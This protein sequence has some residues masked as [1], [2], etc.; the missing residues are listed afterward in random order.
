MR[1][2]PALAALT[3]TLL[4]ALPAGA[5]TSLGQALYEARCDKCHDTSVHARNPRSAKSFDEIR[6][7]V[8]RWD[9]ELGTA[10]TDEEINEVARY[11]NERYYKFPCPPSVC[12]DEQA[13]LR[14]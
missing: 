1:P 5:D 2:L 8:A 9:K 12:K 13:R 11:L 3:L 14:P 4:A 10:W 6:G 7:F